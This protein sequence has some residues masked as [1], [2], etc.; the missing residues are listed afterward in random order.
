MII[1]SD[2]RITFVFGECFTAHLDLEY[3]HANDFADVWGYYS[4]FNQIR[5]GNLSKGYAL[6]WRNAQKSAFWRLYLNEHPGNVPAKAAWDAF[7]PLRLLDEVIDLGTDKGERVVVDAFGFQ[8]GLVAAVTVHVAKNASLTVEAWVERL[9]QLRLGQAFVAGGEPRNLEAVLI[10]LLDGYRDARFTGVPAG[11]RSAEPFSINTV[12]QA[13]GAA[14][15]TRVSTSLHR[16]LHAVTAWPPD[17]KNALLPPADS[18][19]HFLPI[20]GR[21]KVK[22]DVFYAAPRGRTIWRPGLFEQQ[23]P[24]DGPQRRHTLSCMAHN[25]V[26]GAVQAE[27]FRLLAIRAAALPLDRLFLDTATLRSVGLKI[28][29]MRSG[30]STFRSSSIKSHLEESSGKFEVNKLLALAQAPQIP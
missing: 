7:V 29:H 20:R 9:R 8:F 22:G 15:A 30:E 27:M 1:V 25:L 4:A 18:A 5:G 23:R 2:A 28:G 12:L 24:E 19:E 26:A 13:S 3:A 6:P 21:A 17:W 11:T 10:A 14:P 16:A